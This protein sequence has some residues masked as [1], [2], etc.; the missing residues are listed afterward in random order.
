MTAD[1][2]GRA[3]QALDPNNVELS[4]RHLPT[5]AIETI[6]QAII[7]P[8]QDGACLPY[9]V[10]RPDGSSCQ[11]ARSLLG[12]R[13]FSDMA[14]H[15]DTPTKQLKG[16]YLFGGVARVHFGHFL[17]ESLTRLWASTQ[18]RGD[19]DGII[20]LHRPTHEPQRALTKNYAF[21]YSALG[22][23]IPF[24][25]VTHPTQIEKLHVPTPGFGHG[26]WITGT[27]EFRK[28]VRDTL[29]SK[30]TANGPA[31][32]YI[33]RSRLKEGL[34]A[35]DQEDRIER[36]M[37]AAGYTIF[38]PQL[39]SI[40]EQCEH[41][42][43]ARIIVGGDG[44]AFHLAGFFLSPDCKVGLI[45]RRNRQNVYN[46]FVAQIAAFSDAEVTAINC[47]LDN[48]PPHTTLEEPINFQKLQAEL[49][50]A[51]FLS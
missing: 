49:T 25:F 21:L 51:G 46:S 40:Q 18:I 39:H 14:R 4:A 50:S 33:S 27:P 31:R 22:Q 42:R 38:H 6:D 15:P 30:V 48:S 35:V 34:P 47:L 37:Q 44:S 8:I 5:A 24:H 45:Q 32:L 29:V 11:M 26:H 23:G 7:A 13:R 36:L 41:Y 10:F 20:F 9:G 12:H 28:H 2:S 17:L 19:I 1:K 3:S 16:Q 43:A